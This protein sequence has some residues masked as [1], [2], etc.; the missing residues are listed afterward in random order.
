[1]NQKVAFNRYNICQQG[2]G[3]LRP[4]SEKSFCAFQVT[5]VQMVILA[6]YLSPGTHWKH[7]DTL[8]VHLDGSCLWLV[9]F[10][11]KHGLLIAGVI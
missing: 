9:F 2:L 11:L 8:I 4:Q 1:M 7:P 3:L 10:H 6:A 5:E